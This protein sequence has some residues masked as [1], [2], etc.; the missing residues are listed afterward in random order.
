LAYIRSDASIFVSKDLADKIG[1][2]NYY[3]VPC[4]VDFKIFKPMEQSAARKYF[5]LSK[6][7]KYILFSS[8]F[9]NEIKNY[10]LAKQAVEE[11][12][13]NQPEILELIGYNR[14]EVSRLMNAADLALL[15]S[16][17]EGSPQFIKE[18]M[19]CNVPVVSTNVGDVRELIG[20]TRGCYICDEDSS[21]I[22]RSIQNALNFNKK[23]EGRKNI[24]NLDLERIT[25]QIIK[26]Y[27]TIL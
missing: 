1:A 8:H 4:G 18:A 12:S 15:T 2:K 16:K 13:G 24:E 27:K 10:A 17:S 26:V 6:S 19:A 21:E 23:T 9:S 14:E 5:G 20:S 7:K 11:F 25:D 22:A 3:Y